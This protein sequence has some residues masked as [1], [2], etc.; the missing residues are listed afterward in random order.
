[1]LFRSNNADVGGDNVVDGA[2]AAA[3]T[4]AAG[5][6]DTVAITSSVD[7][8]DDTA[9]TTAGAADADSDADSI[10]EAAFDAAVDS[11]DNTETGEDI[12]VSGAAS[13]TARG[14]NVAVTNDGDAA[15]DTAADA[16]S[17]MESRV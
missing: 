12:F 3:T 4:A 13:D 10:F 11:F 16:A 5:T 17:S 14:D 1:M 8:V 2:A 9:A 7:A 15:D 6:G